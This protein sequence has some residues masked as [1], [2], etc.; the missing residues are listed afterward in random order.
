M[1][2]PFPRPVLSLARSYRHSL[3]GFT[4]LELFAVVAVFGLLASIVLASLT[5]ARSKARDARRISD[6]RQIATALALYAADNS[7]G[8]YPA[9]GGWSSWGAAWDTFIP[10][11]YIITVPKDPL[12]IDLGLCETQ[13]NC[14]V[15]HYCSSGG[16][17]YVVTANLENPPSNPKGNNSSCQIGGPNWYWVS[18]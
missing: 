13:Q 4:L 10:S 12:N 5:S 6:L 3:T 14:Y 2:V 15:Y 1:R 11:Q 16:T 17:S 7:G 18:Q 9:W 8:T